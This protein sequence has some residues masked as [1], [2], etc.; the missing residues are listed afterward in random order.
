MNPSWRQTM[1]AAKK[2]EATSRRKWGTDYGGIASE[3]IRRG[4]TAKRVERRLKRAKQKL[5]DDPFGDTGAL[6]NNPSGWIK[7]KAVR[8]VRK[9]GTYVVE[10]KR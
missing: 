7:A 9:G 4:K 1:K 2:R 3:I 5:S 8:V 6:F 10:V